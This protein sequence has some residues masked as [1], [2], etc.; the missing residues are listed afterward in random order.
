MNESSTD[1]LRDGFFPATQWTLVRAAQSGDPADAEQAM[2]QICRRYWYPIYAYLRRSRHSAHDAEDLTQMFFE[3]L[4]QRDSIGAIRQEGGKLRS[5]LLGSLKRVISDQ[6]RHDRAQKRGGGVA[7]LSFDE[8]EAEQRYACEPQDTR[9]PESIFL[10]AWAYD[11]LASIREKLR[12]AFAV[13]GREAVFETLLPFLM[14][15]E[16][17]PSHR[18]IAEKLGCSE[19]SSR[20]QIMRLRSKFRTLL[21]EELACTVLTPEDIPGELAWLRSV[22][23]SK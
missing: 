7:D 1:S 8:M 17:P 18:E 13:T 22:L 2:N 11:L 16:D 19:A 15:D 3:R 5:F 12:A 20:V 9:D 14:W 10:N 4:L 21:E 23:A 6:S